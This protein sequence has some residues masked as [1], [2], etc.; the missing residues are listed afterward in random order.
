MNVDWTNASWRKAGTSD[1][2]GC[3]E[4]AYVDGWVGVR[5]TKQ[6]G[7]GPVLAFNEHEWNSF[8]TG[9]ANGEFTLDALRS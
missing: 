2:G 1:T 7:N 5:D 3:V 9:V 4:V 6:H 8:L